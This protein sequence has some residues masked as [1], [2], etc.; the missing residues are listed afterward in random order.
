MFSLLEKPEVN[1]ERLIDEKEFSCS[2]YISDIL[3]T[4]SSDKI[5]KSDFSS[6]IRFFLLL[7]KILLNGH[8]LS[9]CLSI[10]KFSTSE[11]QNRIENHWKEPQS[12]SKSF[13]LSKISRNP[14]LS[15]DTQNSSNRRKK[16][17][18]DPTRSSCK[19]KE[20]ISIINWN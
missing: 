13:S 15:H 19:L 8:W 6:E 11:C 4:S 7:S 18:P 14:K 10:M 20:K 2:E 5:K 17:P 1:S 9:I 3:S 12:D 16:K